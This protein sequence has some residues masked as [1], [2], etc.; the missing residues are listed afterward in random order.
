MQDE[1]TKPIFVVGSY[2]S[3]TSI[4]TWC[5][6]QHPNIFPVEEGNWMGDFALAID[7]GYRVGTARGDR[8]ILSAMDISRQEFFT[9][10][11]RSINQLLLAH[12]PDL[13]R[14][15][16]MRYPVSEPKL[17][18]VDGAPENSVDIYA[19]RQLFPE[20]IFIHILRDVRDVVRSLLNFHR[21]A[22]THLV[23]NE[24]QAYRCWL[25][26]VKACV[27]AEL[28]YGPRVI[29]RFSYAGLV[30]NPES[31]IRSLLEFANESYCAKCLEPLGRRINS[32][33]VPA[34]FVAE[35]PATDPRAVEEAINLYT[36]LQ[37]TPQ[38]TEPSLVALEEMR[39]RFD[40]RVQDM[41][42]VNKHLEEALRTISTFDKKNAE[43]QDARR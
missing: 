7:A 8:S 38:P 10:L 2:R 21:V 6:G 18:W 23:K 31:A 1:T 9:V 29:H 22:G 12:L 35:D 11:G 15:R 42:T 27:Q 13:E 16:K 34:D 3:G 30:E 26:M 39:R 5:L 4:L 43:I 36:E 25:R 32:S 24:E 41:A 19:L 20:A 37:E 33:N 14:K 40:Q 17:R 28:A